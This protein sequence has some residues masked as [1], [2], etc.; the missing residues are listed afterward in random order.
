M[1]KKPQHLKKSWQGVEVRKTFRAKYKV[2][3]QLQLFILT[4]EPFFVALKILCSL[5]SYSFYFQLEK[6]V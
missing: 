4:L 6:K 2:L 1:W 3:M 5:H